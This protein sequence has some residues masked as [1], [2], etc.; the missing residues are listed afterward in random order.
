MVPG[1]LTVY[2]VQLSPCSFGGRGRTIYYYPKKPN[3]CMGRSTRH[4]VFIDKPETVSEILRD[5]NIYF[6]K[7]LN[8]EA[9]LLYKKNLVANNR[10]KDW[11]SIIELKIEDQ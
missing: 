5:I 4:M 2:S 6:F 10:T 8:L 1:A 9:Y 11:R 7:F 3:L